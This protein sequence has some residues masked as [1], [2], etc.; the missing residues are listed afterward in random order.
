MKMDIDTKALIFTAGQQD[1]FGRVSPLAVYGTTR[2][3]RSICVTRNVSPHV[4]PVQMVLDSCEA[5]EM[6]NVYVTYDSC[7]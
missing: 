5:A 6:T 7:G 3:G 2:T 1:Q 4:A